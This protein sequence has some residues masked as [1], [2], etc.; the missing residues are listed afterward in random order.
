VK[1]SS[2]VV[3]AT[4]ITSDGLNLVRNCECGLRSQSYLISFQRSDEAT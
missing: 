3:A 2:I 1:Y 4:A